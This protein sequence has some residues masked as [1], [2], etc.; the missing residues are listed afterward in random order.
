MVGKDTLNQP[1]TAVHAYVNTRHITLKCNV[2]AALNGV[3]QINMSATPVEYDELYI[4]LFLKS[5]YSI[6]QISLYQNPSQ[7]SN[8]SVFFGM[9]WCFW[10]IH[11]LT[12]E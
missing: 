3:V 2:S 4:I 11:L 7:F 8:I 5:F 1:S 6:R 9:G 12:F 10:M